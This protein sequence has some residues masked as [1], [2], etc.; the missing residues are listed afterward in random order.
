MPIFLNFFEN[1]KIKKPSSVEGVNIYRTIQEAINN[2]LK[3]A[4]ANVSSVNIKPIEN[5]TLIA[6]KDNGK[7]FDLATI[8]KGNGLNN[9]K[10]RI[11]E[12]N[13]KFHLLS[14]DGGT[15]IEILI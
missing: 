8:E 2:S 11:E 6:I 10:K 4:E 1:L 14:N 15:K 7:G 12:I 9:M 13:G 3:Y 5:Q